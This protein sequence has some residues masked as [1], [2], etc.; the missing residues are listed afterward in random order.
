MKKQGTCTNCTYYMAHYIIG[1]AQLVEID[2]H[3]MN[4]DRGQLEVRDRL[5]SRCP[6]FEESVGKEEKQREDIGQ[7]LRGIKKQI[8]EIAMILN[9]ISID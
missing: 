8:D 7:T 2:G 6:L 3:C 1:N 5:K 4:K 9:P